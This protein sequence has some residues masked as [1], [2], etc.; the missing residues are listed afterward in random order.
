MGSI[1]MN[2]IEP[3][4]HDNYCIIHFHEQKE[5]LILILMKIILYFLIYFAPTYWCFE[6]ENWNPEPTRDEN[7]PSFQ[8]FVT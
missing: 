6:C 4:W 7:N 5:I 1:Q 2:L 3:N 8:E